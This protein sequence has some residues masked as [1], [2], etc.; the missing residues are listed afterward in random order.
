MK[1]NKYE[2]LSAAC[3]LTSR[4]ILIIGLVQPVYRHLTELRD[5]SRIILR[6]TIPIDLIISIIIK[7]T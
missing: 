1:E 7:Y 4:L 2:R 6:S 5:K 3:D